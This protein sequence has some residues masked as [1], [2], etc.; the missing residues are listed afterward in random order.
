[1]A[2]STPTSGRAWAPDVSTFAAQDVIPDAL[3]LQTS[4]VSGSIEGDQPAL[5]VAFVNDANASFTAEGA[6][7]TESDPELDEVLVY[8]AKISKL[9]N[10]TNE[11]YR[12]EGTA[13]QLS[14]SVQ[15]AIVKEANRA[16]LTQILPVSPA[17]APRPACST[18][19]ASK[20]VAQ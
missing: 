2:L 16:Y 17:V 8:T 19:P 13:T 4:T 18:S 6:P 15:R 5:R 10:I 3:I 11:Q 1:M 20:T 9:V 14:A 12:Q 7:I